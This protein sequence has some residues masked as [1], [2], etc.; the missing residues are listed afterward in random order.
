M[1]DILNKIKSF[2]DIDPK[3]EERIWESADKL[4]QNLRKDMD[5]I[6]FCINFMD[7]LSKSLNFDNNKNI[8]TFIISKSKITI[9]NKYVDYDIFLKFNNYLYE[10]TNVNLVTQ[11]DDIKT[12]IEF[13]SYIN[14]LNILKIKFDKLNDLVQDIYENGARKIS[15]ILDA[16]NQYMASL[17]K[18]AENAQEKL[19]KTYNNSLNNFD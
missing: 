13:D 11:C 12:T 4:S 2:I 14:L 15:N 17:N 18:A 7:K 3:F 8:I 19:T 9:N 10:H 16:K 1:D 5:N 6:M